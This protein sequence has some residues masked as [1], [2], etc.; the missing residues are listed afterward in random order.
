MELAIDTATEIASVALSSEGK[1]EAEMSWPSGQNHTVEL[2]PNLLHLLRQAKIEPGGQWRAK[3]QA[4]I[5][6][7]GPGSFNGLR[8]GVSTA[9]GLAFALD[10]PLVGIGTLEVEAF[11]YAETGLPI[12]PLQEAGRGEIATALY[13]MQIGEW[14]K[15]VAEHITTVEGLCPDIVSRTLFCGRFSPNTAKRIAENLGERAVILPG[16]LR[17]A[18]FLAELGWKRLERGERDDVA[19]VQPLYLR[20]PAITKPK[21]GKR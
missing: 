16:T 5:V 2:I 4:I 8:V 21:K 10:I 11:P 7:K 17:R 18:G 15:I 12:C 3:I 1:V 19:T 14:Q 9:K 13:Q 20:R 6:S